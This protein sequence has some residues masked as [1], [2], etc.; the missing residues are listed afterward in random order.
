M[1]PNAVEGAIEREEATRRA[2][3]KIRS[4]SLSTAILATYAI[5][6]SMFFGGRSCVGS[7]EDLF[8]RRAEHRKE[9]AAAYAACQ[10][11]YGDYC[12][13]SD[14]D[15]DEDYDEDMGAQR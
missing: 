14:G 10:K 1:D 13:R 4:D 6:A 5:L 3:K 7:R 8:L 2:W 15:C 12:Q 11:R 9:C